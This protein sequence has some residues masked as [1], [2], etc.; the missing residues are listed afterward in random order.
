MRLFSLGGFLTTLY[1]PGE[2]GPVGVAL[3]EERNVAF[4]DWADWL[5]IDQRERELGE[6]EQRERIKL[7]EREDFLKAAKG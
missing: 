7:V 1:L 2:V 3:L 4:I 5:M 6:A